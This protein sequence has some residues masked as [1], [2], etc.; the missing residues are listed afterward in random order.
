MLGN[1]RMDVAGCADGA[2]RLAIVR[3]K[4]RK[5][6]WVMCGDIV[7][8]GLRSFQDEKCDIIHKYNN[9]EIRNL[10]AY[11]EIPESIKINDVDTPQ[12]G[13]AGGDDD[14]V[15]FRDDIPN[16]DEV[17]VKESDR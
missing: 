17:D 8:V 15:S 6:V 10:K 11:N 1:G 14:L 4:M 5:R 9:D 13:A 12:S 2:R 3:G 16:D 7:L